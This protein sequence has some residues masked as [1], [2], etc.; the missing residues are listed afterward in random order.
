[1]AQ[2]DEDAWGQQ[3]ELERTCS[4]VDN[5]NE[6]RARAVQPP[7]TIPDYSSVKRTIVLAFLILSSLAIYCNWEKIMMLYQTFNK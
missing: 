3:T 1:M 7:E 2:V 6:R 5:W 4:R